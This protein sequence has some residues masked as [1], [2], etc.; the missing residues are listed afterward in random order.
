MTESFE[1]LQTAES[2]NHIPP[3]YNNLDASLS[4]AWSLLQHGTTDRRSAF[5]APAVASIGVDGAPRQRTM[6]LRKVDPIKRTLR[7]NTDA[8]SQKWQELVQLPHVSVLA[9]SAWDKVQVRLSGFATLDRHSELAERV[10]TSMRDQSR[11]AYAQPDAPGATIEAPDGYVPPLELRV[12]DAAAT[13]ARE[14]FCLLTVEVETLDWVYLNLC[15][16]RRA[17]FRWP[18]GVLASHWLAP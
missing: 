10:W 5:H 14:H 8:R 9:Y 17:Q 16:N 13:V 11:V 3:F 4:M 2:A 1:T 6:V 7:F 18:D 12:G 15:G